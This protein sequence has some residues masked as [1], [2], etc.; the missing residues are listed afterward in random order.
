MRGQLKETVSFTIG[1][2]KNLP[3][4]EFTFAT[5]KDQGKIVYRT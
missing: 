3:H 4:L 2:G 5:K 1:G